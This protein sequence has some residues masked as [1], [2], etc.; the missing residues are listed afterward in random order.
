MIVT[1]QGALLIKGV[2]YCYL[3]MALLFVL[4]LAI[5]AKTLIELVCGFYRKFMS[6][7]GSRRHA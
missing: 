3:W 1:L 7:L 4:L 2:Q 6:L 5:Q